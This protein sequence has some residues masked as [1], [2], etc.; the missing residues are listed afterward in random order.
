MTEKEGTGKIGLNM[1]KGWKKDEWRSTPF[2]IG[3]KEE[4]ILIYHAEFGIHRSRNRS[5]A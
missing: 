5:S 2:G 3:S 1:R 4:E